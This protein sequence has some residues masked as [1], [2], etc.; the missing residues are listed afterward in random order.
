MVYNVNYI[1]G[2]EESPSVFRKQDKMPEAGSVVY[3]EGKQF[4]VE[5]ATELTRQLPDRVFVLAKVTPAPS[6]TS[7]S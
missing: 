2:D 1:L 3:L 4:I 7:E 5:E 6:T